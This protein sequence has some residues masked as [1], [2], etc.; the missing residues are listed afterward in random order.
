MLVDEL[1]HICVVRKIDPVH[2]ANTR[3]ALNSPLAAAD[4]YISGLDDL[5]ML[6]ERMPQLRGHVLD[7]RHVFEIDRHEASRQQIL[8]SPAP[9]IARRKTI[10]RA[11]CRA[12]VRPYDEIAVAA[13]P[14]NTTRK[15]TVTSTPLPPRH[16]QRININ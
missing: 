2:L 7:R 1:G 3:T 15:Q 6:R 13:V 9:H 12:R 10:G 4:W 5:V 8:I 11:S 16:Y 14:L